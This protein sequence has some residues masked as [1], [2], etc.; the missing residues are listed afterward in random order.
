VDG[1]ELSVQSGTGEHYDVRQLLSASA[2]PYVRRLVDAFSER[3]VA[4]LA[5]REGVTFREIA[6]LVDGF[7]AQIPS[8]ELGHRLRAHVA[9]GL[10]LVFASDLLGR[11]RNLPRSVDLVLTR[12]ALDLVGPV[13]ASLAAGDS[14]PFAASVA[15]L[16][17]GLRGPELLQ[18]W[19]N[20]DL[21]YGAMQGVAHMARVD[22][23]RAIVEALGTERLV[24]AGMLQLD[25]REIRGPG[26]GHEA[27]LP[28]LIAETLVRRDEPDSYDL[29]RRFYEAGIIGVAELPQALR[30][31]ADAELLARELERDAVSMLGRLQAI[32]ELDAYAR[33]I[34]RVRMA[35]RVL[36]RRG[37]TPALWATA[38]RLREL[39]AEAPPGERSHEALAARAAETIREPDVLGSIAET[40]L[41]GSS[42]QRDAGI[43]ILR[44]AGSAGARALLLSRE[45]IPFEQ[46][47]RA[48][49]VAAMRAVGDVGIAVVAEQLAQ[50]ASQGPRCSPLLAED[51]LRAL[52][53]RPLEKLGPLVAEFARHEAASVRRAAVHVLAVTLGARARDW[54]VTALTDTDDGV[55][56]AGLAGLRQAGLVDTL[57]VSRIDRIVNDLSAAE[58]LRAA[59]AGTLSAALPDARPAAIDVLRRALRPVRMSFMTVFK[60]VGGGGGESVLVLTTIARVLMAIAGPLGRR[61]VEARA[62]VSRGELKKALNALLG[63]PG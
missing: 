36:A 47:M 45:R 4:C 3:D 28:R 40:L 10:V 49:F 50:L 12:L 5:L 48:R 59:A 7:E 52:P 29:L 35:M 62:K 21:V 24:E 2:E 39:A 51:L 37:R 56:I 46:A 33:E 18:L 15:D 32:P 43:G 1:R 42:D 34:E 8:A 58:E 17:S 55:R 26:T 14:A 31:F 30:D 61:E 19:R 44:G 63:L 60:D 41:R 53:E 6:A 13:G 54:L 23:R 27:S 11:S 16:A 57:A 22:V 25:E 20:V 38:A 9:H